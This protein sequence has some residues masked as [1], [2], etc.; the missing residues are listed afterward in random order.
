MTPA[1]KIAE[2]RRL[3]LTN[4]GIAAARAHTPAEAVAALCAMQAQDYAGGLWAIGLRLPGGTVDDVQRAIAE[5]TVV[6]TWPLR[7]TLHFVATQDVR[8]MM[9]L[10]AP[11]VIA[12]SSARHAARGLDAATFRKVEKLLVRALQGGKQLTREAA[13]VLLERAKTM[14]TSSAPGKRARPSD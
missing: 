3:R 2:L 4:Q 7:G 12:A 10:L 11:R 8:W 14:G 5:H 9:N 13:R 6:R 1:M